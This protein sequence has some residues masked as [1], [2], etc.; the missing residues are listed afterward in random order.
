VYPAGR[1]FFSV[2]PMRIF[3]PPL[4]TAGRNGQSRGLLHA[5]SST[6]LTLPPPLLRCKAAPDALELSG[7]KGVLEALLTDNTTT[8]DLACRICRL[9]TDGMEQIR[10]HTLAVGPS[11]PGTI[12]SALHPSAAEAVMGLTPPR[13]NRG[14][15]MS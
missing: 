7:S 8:A 2:T 5:E 15:G 10:V 1:E 9:P 13:E 6:T 11:D 3:Y 12:E 4:P 14:S